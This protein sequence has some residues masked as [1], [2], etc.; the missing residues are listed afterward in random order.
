MSR[1]PVWLDCDPG[2]D[3]AMAILLAGHSPALNLLGIST[4][5]GNQSLDKTTYN[6]L[7]VLHVGGLENITVVPGQPYP[8]VAP[9]VIC[10]EIHG[11]TGLDGTNLPPPQRTALDQK[12]IVHMAE[13]LVK[14]PEPVTLIATGRL[15]NVALLVTVYPEV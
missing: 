14:H 6:A 7:Q 1:H 13:V 4:V 11:G 5:G 3:D 15:T 9:D 10:P 12:A 2:H 8:L